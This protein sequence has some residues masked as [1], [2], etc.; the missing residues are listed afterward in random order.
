VQATSVAPHATGTGVVAPRKPRTHITLIESLR[1]DR[2]LTIE[3]VHHATGVSMKT[4]TRYET[5]AT[6]RPQGDALVKLGRFYGVKASVLLA[7][8]RRTHAE[9]AASSAPEGGNGAVD[10]NAPIAVYRRNR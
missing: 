5:V 7:D 6:L 2:G 10:A 8:M 3:S 4:I 1:V 9:W